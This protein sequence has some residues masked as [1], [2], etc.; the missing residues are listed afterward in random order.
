MHRDLRELLPISVLLEVTSLDSLG[1][2]KCQQPNTLLTSHLI[3]IFVFTV[4][5]I[6]LSL[7]IQEKTSSYSF[8][9]CLAKEPLGGCDFFFPQLSGYIK[10]LTQKGFFCMYVCKRGIYFCTITVVTEEMLL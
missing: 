8:Q 3:K 7:N 2:R 4:G 6:F 1:W 10:I 5:L 9:I